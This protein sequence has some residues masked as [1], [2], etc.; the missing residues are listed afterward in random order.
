MLHAADMACQTSLAILLLLAGLALG[1]AAGV[2]S[3]GNNMS[4]KATRNVCLVYYQAIVYCDEGGDPSKFT[5][6]EVELFRKTTEWIVANSANQEWT[7]SN[8]TFTCMGF[9]DL[10]NDL[11]LPEPQRSCDVG[12]AGIS[13]TTERMAAGYKFSAPTYESGRKIMIY[14]PTTTDPF[15]F[16]KPFDMTVWL[17]I[18]ATSVFVGIA[19]MLAEVPVRRIIRQPEPSLQKYLNLQWASTAM[20]L[21]AMQQFSA[22]TV[23]ARFIIL[24]YAFMVLILVNAYI[25]VLS[26][27]LTVTSI[28]LNINGLADLLSKP[29]GIFEPDVNAFKRFNLNYMVPLPWNSAE[30]EANMLRMLRSAEISA[31]ILDAPFVEYQVASSCDLYEVGDTL[32]PVNLAFTFPPD[33]NLDYIQLFSYGLTALQEAGTTDDLKTN[34]IKPSGGCPS[35]SSSNLASAQITMPQVAGLWVFLAAACVAGYGYNLI[36]WINS[37]VRRRMGYDPEKILNNGSV[38]GSMSNNPNQVLPSIS[39]SLKSAGRSMSLMRTNP[40]MAWI[41]VADA[42]T[43]EEGLELLEAHMR[44]VDKR[45][46]TFMTNVDLKFNMLHDAITASKD[47]SVHYYKGEDMLDPTMEPLPNMAKKARK[48]STG[49][50]ED[51]LARVVF[52][53]PSNRGVSFSATPNPT[54]TPVTLIATSSPGAAV[55]P[56]VSDDNVHNFNS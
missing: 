30:D 14:A 25:A 39:G 28:N 44:N 20:L 35:K 41:S 33:V 9:D 38:N 24:G 5:G 52:N 11:L 7:A 46:K 36:V 3:S 48:G 23:G 47:P 17:V 50:A 31:L 2:V 22:K 21:Q 34:F 37:L 49:T 45:I 54:P 32:L 6:Y 53:E 27:Q 4:T 43:T 16:L 42:S 1:Q 26:S 40:D 18:M 55:L 29:V 10:M 56:A 13:A 19:V 12:V 8:Y 51:V 15:L